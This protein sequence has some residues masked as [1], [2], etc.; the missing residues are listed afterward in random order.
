MNQ[1]ELS[2]WL[3]G[4]LLMS[5]VLGLFLCFG[6]APNMGSTLAESDPSRAHLFWPCLL[7]IWIA[8]IPIY[9]ALYQA[10]MIFKNVGEDNSFCEEN[11]LRLKKVSRLSIIVVLM[12]SCAAF[13]LLIVDLV[14]F[15]IFLA[16][17]VILF[18]SIFVAVSSAVLSHLV[19]K[20]VEL[21]KE[22]DLTI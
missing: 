17:F 9:M 10:W 4:L 6:L 18:A 2:I 13:W 16:I 11:M 8:C 5:G 3:K 14:N 12:Y 7:F 21:Q 19:N 1:R 20:A 15:Y 22:N